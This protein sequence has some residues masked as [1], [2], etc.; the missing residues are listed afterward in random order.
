WRSAGRLA[1]PASAS[2]RPSRQMR[3]G[4]PLNI[5]P[6]RAWDQ[7]D[8]A[9]EGAGGGVPWP[10]P[11]TTPNRRIRVT[12]TTTTI[13]PTTMGNTRLRDCT[14]GFGGAPAL[15]VPAAAAPGHQASRGIGA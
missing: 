4:D 12:P 7:C 2:G 8:D 15:I 11:P 9:G 13:T 10:P 6:L 14:A 1:R 3:W 5:V